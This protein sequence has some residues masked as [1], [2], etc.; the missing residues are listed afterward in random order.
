MVCT[1]LVGAAC[2]GAMAI[3]GMPLA[4]VIVLL[5]IAVA[6][7]PLF[8][9]AE[10][11]QLSLSLPSPQYRVATAARMMGSQVAQISGFALG[12]VLVAA[13]GARTSLLI[14]AA[15]FALSALLILTLLREGT[16]GP[17]RAAARP[18]QHPVSAPPEFR[19]LWRTPR[20][21]LLLVLGGLIGLFVVPEGLAVPYGQRIGA[22]TVD[23]GLLLCSAALGGAIGSV[24]VVRLIAPEHRMTSARLMAVAC[25]L[26]LV[27][28]VV[29]DHWPAA[30]LCWLASGIFAAY[31]V[32][33]TSLLVQAVPTRRRAHY[34][35]VVNTVLLVSQGLGMLAF[36]AV[37]T[38]VSP[39]AAIAAAGAVGSG[40]ALLVA[41]ATRA[42]R[43][44]G[45]HSSRRARE[46]APLRRSFDLR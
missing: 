38:A 40:V 9:S 29:I 23:I 30:A 19:G 37:S 7:A 43:K 36:G 17:I 13:T 31:I 41:L 20:L 14:D 10:V 26:P 3:P 18:A 45:A 33:V 12:G 22:S 1:A 39:G 24:L 35:G 42:Q 21:R 5:V 4:L 46:Q 15:T 6:I 25:G 8:S 32:E 11:S 34:T 16:R 28:I 2:F 27:P 44:A